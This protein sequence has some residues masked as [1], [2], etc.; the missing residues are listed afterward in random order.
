MRLTRRGKTV[1]TMLMMVVVLGNEIMAGASAAAP[2]IIVKQAPVSLAKRQMAM[3]ATWTP[4]AAKA[5]AKR[6]LSLYGWAQSEFRCLEQMW[7][8]ESNWR[9]KAQNKQHVYQVRKGKRVRLYAGGIPQL[10]GLNAKTTPM[11]EQ[12]GKGLD[13]IESRYDTPCKAWKFWQRNS[14]Y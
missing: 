13:Y 10:L 8:K 11:P 2:T 7:T 3:Q 1:V 12:I 6:R 14:F 4:E 5:V 9:W